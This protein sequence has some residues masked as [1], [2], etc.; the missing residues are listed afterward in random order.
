METKL[1]TKSF[2]PLRNWKPTSRKRGNA[3]RRLRLVGF[4]VIE[5]IPAL[6]SFPCEPR[7]P[8]KPPPSPDPHRFTSTLLMPTSPDIP[9]QPHVWR[10]SFGH[11]LSCTAKLSPAGELSCEWSRRPPVTNRGFVK[12]HT[13]WMTHL[14][15]QAAQI[16][17]KRIMQDIQ[18]G[19]GEF[20]T[21]IAEPGPP[22]H[23]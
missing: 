10:H 9:P 6:F 2:P 21:I 14:T 11:G 7:H 22:A 20:T 1:E 18:T 23:E 4:H 8:R 5:P 12:A 15:K 16:T 13:R 19:P 17:G 3:G